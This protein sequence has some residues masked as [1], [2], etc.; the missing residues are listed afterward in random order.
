M[1]KNVRETSLLSY[2][3]LKS[4]L[5]ERYSLCI[6]GL[7]ELEEATANE[8]SMYLF[9]KGK[10]PVFNRHFVHPRLTELVEKG[11]VKEIGKKVD[12]ISNRK[13]LVYTLA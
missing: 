9:E 7:K 8:L 11:I 5:G 12:A 3:A 10:A 13:C 4:E 6:E 2:E 1:K